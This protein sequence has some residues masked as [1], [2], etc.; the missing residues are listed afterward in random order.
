MTKVLMILIAFF[1]SSC[2]ISDSVLPIA[3]DYS[4]D[5]DQGRILITYRNDSGRTVCLTPASW[6]TSQGIIDN[7]SRRIS[8]IIGK[9]EY[10]MKDIN[11]DYC[12]R[13]A[14]VVEPN[15]EIAAIVPYARFSI[16]ETHVRSSKELQYAPTAFFCRTS[17]LQNLIG[18]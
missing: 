11:T 17:D 12:P 8:V 13:C 15:D 10:P 7:G 14:F 16:P 3:Y 6:P 5:A 2:T 9:L 18:L 1:V 4:D